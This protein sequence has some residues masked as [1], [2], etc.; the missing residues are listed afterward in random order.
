MPIWVTII[1]VAAYVTGAV[2]LFVCAGFGF[3]QHT[4]ERVLEGAG[5]LVLLWM[6]L[7]TAFADRLVIWSLAWLAAPIAALAEVRRVQQA[8]RLRRKQL[9]VTY[10]IEQRDRRP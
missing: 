5:G 1:L 8:E 4:I 3:G 2:I 10:A 7:G 9:A 6:A